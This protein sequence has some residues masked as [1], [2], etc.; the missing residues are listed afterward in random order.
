MLGV[1]NRKNKI[2]IT[3]YPYKRDITNRL[4]LADLT[5]FDIHILQEMLFHP[6]KIQLAELAESASCSVEE[7]TKTLNTFSRVGFTMKEGNTLF[8]DKELRKYFEFHIAKFSKNFEPSFEYLQGLLN[9]V[10]ISVLPTWYSIP[11]TS[12]NI[13]SSIV[14]KY[15]LTPKVYENYLAEVTFSDPLIQHIIRDVFASSELAIPASELCDRYRIPK[16][17]F[18]EYMLLLEFHFV[19]VSSF[20]NRQ[21][22]ISPF[23]EWRE[24]LLH[25]RQRKA[26]A[27]A[28][29]KVVTTQPAIQVSTIRKQ[30]EAMKLFRQTIDLWQSEWSQTL[31]SVERSVYEIEKA[32]RAIAE[33]AWILVDDFIASMICPIGKQEPVQLQRIGKKWR[34]VLPSYSEKERRFIKMVICDLLHQVG[35][36]AVGIVEDQ[37]CFKITPF[38][39]IALGEA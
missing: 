24:Y 22:V 4:F 27:I 36:T 9:K 17:K 18:Q 32:M 23:H 31:S 19:L 3:D 33:E 6:S 26:I 38:G 1:I 28:S 10:P 21:E 39:R 11:R 20:K 34:Y 15:L 13:F 16:D 7:L 8:V 12:D 5:A 25:Q 2:N 35:I 14:E 37:P 29:E 30:E